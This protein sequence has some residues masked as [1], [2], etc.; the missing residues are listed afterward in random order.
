[1]RT[2]QT[3]TR[4]AQARANLDAAR[5]R[6]S[7]LGTQAQIT[8]TQTLAQ[9]QEAEAALAAARQR[10]ALMKEGTR[11][12]EKTQSQLAV[13]Q[14]KANYDNAKAYYERRQQ[15]F[16][17]GAVSKETVDEAERQL[18]VAEAQYQSAQ[19]QS[20]LVQEGFRAQEVRVAEEDVRRAEETVRQAKANVD[21]NKIRKEDIEAARIQVKQA[22]ADLQNAMAGSADFKVT[23]EE[24]HGAE[25]GV[26]Q[27]EATISLAKEQLS[28]ARIVSPVNAVVVTRHVNVGEMASPGMLLMKLVAVDTAYFEG[29]VSEVDISSLTTDLSV[30]VTVDSAP[31]KTFSGSVRRII[32]VASTSNRTFRIRVS[33]PTGTSNST[34]VKPGSFARGELILTTIPD[35]RILPKDAMLKRDDAQAVFVVADG[36]AHEKTVVLGIV[37]D[38]DVQVV[39]GVDVGDQVVVSGADTL[40]DGAKVK[41]VRKAAE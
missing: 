2:S 6:V 38:Q 40:L 23:A 37:N 33:V 14:A 35:A 8:E 17:S 24:I 10:L 4:I 26:Q 21:S 7:Q 19:A 11:K 22:G 27:A 39:S 29:I 1:M 16:Q 18:K 36:V 31:G 30:R 12:Q 34:S 9:V 41:V 25:A 3:K 20:D 5:V 13:N 32:P 15:L 28:N